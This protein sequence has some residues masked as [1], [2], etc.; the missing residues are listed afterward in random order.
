VANRLLICDTDA[1]AT[2]IWHE[3]YLGT[4]AAAID[5]L[6]ATRHYDLYLLTDIDTPF[7][8]DGT[9]DG[10]DIRHWMHV[11]FLEE[12]DHQRRRFALVAG[13]R[14]ERMATAMRQIDAILASTQSGSASTIDAL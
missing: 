1:L 2:N 12:L 6:V 5:A 10:E 13:S 8:Q 7:V 14:E 9:R 4:R 3:R 11:R